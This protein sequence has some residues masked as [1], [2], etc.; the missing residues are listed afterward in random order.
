MADNKMAADL[1]YKA[2][3]NRL[4]ESHKKLCAEYSDLLDNHKSL[5]SEFCRLRAQM[6]VV[7]L[8]FGGK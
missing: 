7:Y 2:E 3:Y 6:D 8:I 5:E 1:D 4:L